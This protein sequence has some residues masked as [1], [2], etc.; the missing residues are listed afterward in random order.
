MEKDINKAAYWYWRALKDGYLRAK[1][2]LDEIYDI[3]MDFKSMHP[4]YEKLHSDYMA[5]ENQKIILL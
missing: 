2:R 1:K 3:A 4:N 5:F